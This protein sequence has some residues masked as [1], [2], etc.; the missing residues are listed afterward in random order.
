MT[1]STLAY[2]EIP[3]PSLSTDK[4]KFG[5]FNTEIESF[6]RIADKLKIKSLK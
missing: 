3:L 5:F 4:Q 2:C 6:K 1:Y